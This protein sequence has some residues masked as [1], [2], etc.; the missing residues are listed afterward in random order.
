MRRTMAAGHL[1]IVPGHGIWRGT[2]KGEASE[3]WLLEPFQVEGHDHLYFIKH[4]ET[5]LRLADDDSE[6]IVMFSGGQTKRQAGC[7][8]EAQ[9][10]YLLAREL[11]NELE[12]RNLD[13]SLER[14]HTEEYARD[15]FENVLFSI[16]RFKEITGSYPERITIPGFEFKRERFMNHHFKALQFDL[17]NVAYIG[18]GPKPDYDEQSTQWLKYFDD[19][20]KAEYKNAVSQFTKDPLGNGPVLGSKKKNRNPFNRQHGYL[21]S[22]PEL[23][24]LFGDSE[25][26]D[27]Y[28]PP[29]TK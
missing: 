9:S 5:A 29:W 15:S 28:T 6:A 26:L 18:L 27:A 2:N 3:D 1:V 10:Y 12:L 4:I 14:C 22:C 24:P 20:K 25:G 8:S 17:N 13:E 21:I 16:A 7:M 11:V 19:L 23:Q